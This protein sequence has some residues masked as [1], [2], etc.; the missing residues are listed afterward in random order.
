MKWRIT[1]LIE[2]MSRNVRKRTTGDLHLTEAPI[3]I[4]IIII[5]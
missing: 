4:I 1:T 3:I 2:R 5:I